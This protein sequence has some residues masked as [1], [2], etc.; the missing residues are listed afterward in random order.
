MQLEQLAFEFYHMKRDH[1]GNEIQNG[2]NSS[3]IS[4]ACTI[5]AI[6]IMCMLRP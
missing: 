2:S 3:Y 6:M 1:E 4:P 5:D